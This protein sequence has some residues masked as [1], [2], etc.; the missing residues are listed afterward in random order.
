MRHSQLLPT[1]RYS[2]LHLRMSGSERN[3]VRRKNGRLG[4]S[5]YI[6]Y[7]PHTFRR[8]AFLSPLQRERRQRELEREKEEKE[9]RENLEV[10][11][12]YSNPLR[13]NALLTPSKGEKRQRE[14]K[15]ED[16]GTRDGGKL[17]HKAQN[18]R[19]K[20][21]GK[22]QSCSRLNSPPTF[23]PDRRSTK[24]SGLE[25]AHQPPSCPVRACPSY[26]GDLRR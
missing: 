18:V 25:T 20:T 4:N 2:D 14:H 6:I 10:D 23:S 3:N 17:E 11:Y 21:P 1:E 12:C 13:Q 7:D 26:Y 19:E 24:P 16:K 9:D 8:N 15:G 22:Y 5:R